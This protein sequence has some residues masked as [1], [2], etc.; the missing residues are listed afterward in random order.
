VI[1]DIVLT[2]LCVAA[3]LAVVL[4]DRLVV[5]KHLNERFWPNRS[6]TTM[7]H[8]HNRPIFQYRASSDGGSI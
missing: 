5:W 1:F 6:T 8:T 3:L 7:A 4:A 2:V